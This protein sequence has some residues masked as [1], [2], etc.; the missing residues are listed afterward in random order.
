MLVSR[1]NVQ[2]RGKKEGERKYGKEEYIK[3][4]DQ[5]VMSKKKLGGLGCES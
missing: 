3:V 4:S 1:T 5:E 2:E